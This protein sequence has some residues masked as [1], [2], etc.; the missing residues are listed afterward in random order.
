M[1]YGPPGIGKT[2]IGAATPSP[3][4][5]IDDQEDGVSTLKASKLIAADVPV[6]PAVSKWEDVGEVLDQ[7][8]AG[9]HEF[10]TLVID[11][12]GGLERLCHEFVCR[13]EYNGNWGEKGFTGY[14]R[15]FEA[16]LPH[17]RLLLKKLDRLRSDRGMAIV[18][19]AHSLVRPYKNPEGDDYDRWIA[20]LHH[21]SWSV[22]HKWADMI[23]FANYHVKVDDS[24]PRA[25][26]KGGQVR[27]F[28]AEHHAAYDA[29]NRH[30][31]PAMIPMGSSG[32][33]AWNNLIQAIT[34]ARSK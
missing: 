30:G 19:L 17:W 34:E 4:F 3:V 12:L 2:S 16:S 9:K 20:D 8:T 6:L 7:L 33:E 25:K 23:L 15:G 13:T 27:F 24:G 14:A 32:S 11:T 29:K 1:I 5:L 18:A 21:K 10:R 28:N 22:T 31:L 26:G